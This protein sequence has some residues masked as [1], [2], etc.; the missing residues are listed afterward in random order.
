MSAA[1]AKPM[2]WAVDAPVLDSPPALIPLEFTLEPSSSNG[3]VTMFVTNTISGARVAVCGITR[4]GELLRYGGAHLHGLDSSG[5]GGRIVLVDNEDVTRKPKIEMTICARN[6]PVK[7]GIAAHGGVRTINKLH[8]RLKTTLSGDLITQVSKDGS[9][10]ID[11][12]RLG[13][14]GLKLIVSLEIDKLLKECGYET[15][16]SRV[17]HDKRGLST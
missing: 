12:T 7:D 1:S 16:D 4:Q 14:S 17:A 9:T 15:K 13:D 2:I 6:K 3:V 8:T 5:V 11:L 10:W